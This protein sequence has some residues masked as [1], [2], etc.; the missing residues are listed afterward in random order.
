[1]QANV[2]ATLF[3]YESIQHFRSAQTAEQ[4]AKLSYQDVLD[5]VTLIVGNAYLQVIA[6][7]SHVDAQEAQVR[8]AQALYDQAVDELQAGTAPRSMSRGRKF[9]CTPSSTISASPVTISPLPSWLSAV[10]SGCRLG[11]NSNWR[12][13]FR[14]P[15]STLLL[16][17]TR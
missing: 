11:S 10:P 2:S 12:T 1:M 3:S 4:A 9:N 7:G 5:V 15:T 14:I 17:K 8:I 13:S 16:S 6:D